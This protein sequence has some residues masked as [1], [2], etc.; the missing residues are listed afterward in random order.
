M[1]SPIPS[2]PMGK[3]DGTVKP[4]GD[5]RVYREVKTPPLGRLAATAIALE[6][7]LGIGAIGGGI[8]LMAGPD[9]EILPL[10]VSALTGSPFADYF[11]PGAILFTI[12]GLGPL[13][14]ALLAWRRHPVAPF[15]ALAV[16]GALL[17]WLAV[18]IAIVGYANDP[19]LQ[20]LYLG[21]GVVIALVGVVWLRRT[22]FRFVRRSP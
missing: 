19:P 18:E 4:G 14:A 10:P 13:G 16:G 3:G 8:A 15:L 17:I 7:L 11:A 9:G 20:P 22:G 12:L 1:A 5:G 2:P 6:I 21:F